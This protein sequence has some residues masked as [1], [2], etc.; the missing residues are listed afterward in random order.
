LLIHFCNQ[1]ERAVSL[2]P[3]VPDGEEI[4]TRY[5][6]TKRKIVQLRFNDNRAAFLDANFSELIS[7]LSGK[8][9]WLN[10]NILLYDEATPPKLSIS[11]THFPLA[12]K[13]TLMLNLVMNAF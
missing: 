4:M 9:V 10:K 6:K 3:R 12:I 7:L 1:N 5:Y 13:S 8:V 2:F 11:S